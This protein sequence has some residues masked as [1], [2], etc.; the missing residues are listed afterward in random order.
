MSQVLAVR[1]LAAPTLERVR[2]HRDWQLVRRVR[3]EALAS[4]GD[5]PRCEALAHPDVHDSALNAFT[6]LLREGDRVLG[7]TR[8]SA[9]SPR[10]RWRLPAHDVF[11]PEIER[12]FGADAAL[13]EA[14]LTLVA[15]G[16]DDPK[17][18]LIH[19]VRAHMAHCAMEDADW[20]VAA[21]REAQIGFFRRMF[22][23]EIVSGPERCPGLATPRVLMALDYRAQAR[24]L[25][26]RLP[27][28]APGRLDDLAETLGLGA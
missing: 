11:A 7:T 19:L 18:A 14:S 26:K 4:R 8:S 2:Q 12:A 20:L 10:R 16:C 9:A 23:M 13:V 24:V 25:A 27:S 15:P 22:N 3:Y 5:V 21:V 6:F 17:V 28:L 1:P